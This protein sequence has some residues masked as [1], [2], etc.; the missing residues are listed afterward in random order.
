MEEKDQNGHV[1]LA[2]L[3]LKIAAVRIEMRLKIRALEKSIRI[4]AASMDRRLNA[5]NEFRDS[6]NDAAVRTPTREEVGSLVRTVETRIDGLRDIVTDLQL[7]KAN[8]E[9]KASQNSVMV[10]WAIAGI[11][12]ILGILNLI[13]H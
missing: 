12:V 3:N 2:L 1:S 13:R 5:M 10:A 11:G 8:L 7:S 4:A 9:G 6:L